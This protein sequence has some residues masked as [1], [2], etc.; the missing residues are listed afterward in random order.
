MNNIK[1]N[2]AALLIVLIVVFSIGRLFLLAN[3][4]KQLEQSQSQLAQ[5]QA[6]QEA[7]EAEQEKL[8]AQIK[9]SDSPVRSNKLLL[10]GQE[11]SLLR[12]ILDLGGKSLRLNSYAMLPTFRVKNADETMYSASP[13]A[14]V[15]EELPQLDDQGMP[16]GLATE[17]DEE[18]PGVEIMPVKL[19][20]TS[21]YRSFGKFLSEAGKLM[22]VSAVRSLDLLL[23]N[24]GI[25]KGT[26][27]M[28]FPVAET[29]K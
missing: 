20:F 12:S 8:S 13:M 9:K 14:A 15:S 5:Y 22:P 4:Q 16:V 28:N 1:T 21:T 19:T 23:K 18:W 11:A 24:E 7:I 17:S 27:I 6:N 26:L 25:V 29:N 2:L 3:L 10:P